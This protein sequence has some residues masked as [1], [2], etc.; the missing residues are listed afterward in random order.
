LETHANMV[1]L[2]IFTV[3]VGVVG[4][5]DL[6]PKS[7]RTEHD[8]HIACLM[9]KMNERNVVIDMNAARECFKEYVCQNGPHWWTLSY[10]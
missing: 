8:T 1:K 5:L 10:L 6:S 2:F 4:A 7:C 9:E 3:V